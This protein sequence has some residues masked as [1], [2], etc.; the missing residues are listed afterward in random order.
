MKAQPLLEGSNTIYHYK[1]LPAKWIKTPTLLDNAD[2]V[3]HF[4]GRGL[5]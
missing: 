3:I 4:G 2:V 1:L 5:Q